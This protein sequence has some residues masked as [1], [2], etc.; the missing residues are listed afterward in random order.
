[1]AQVTGKID[2]FIVEVAPGELLVTLVR[3]YYSLIYVPWKWVSGERFPADGIVTC[4]KAF[5]LEPPAEGEQSD[6][7]R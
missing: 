2:D 7:T 5:D 4:Y 1:M 3:W 6:T